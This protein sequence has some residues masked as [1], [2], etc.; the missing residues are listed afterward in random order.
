[1]QI[2][3]EVRREFRGSAVAAGAV[4]LQGRGRTP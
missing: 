2:A 3:L 1:L 4:L